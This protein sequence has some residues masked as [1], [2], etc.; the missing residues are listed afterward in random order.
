[1]IT[2]TLLA[3]T[4]TLLGLGA[5][6]AFALRRARASL[7]Y[8][9]H[10]NGTRGKSSVTRLIAAGLRAGG[11]RTCAKITGT[12][13]RMI[14]PDGNEF[15]VY[16][17]A[18]PNV[19]E[20]VRMIRIAAAER[21]EALVL[22]CMALQ[23]HLQAL[24][25]LDMLQATH[26]VITNARPDH[27]DVMGPDAQ[28]VARALAG[29]T[30]RGARLYT[31]EAQH[32]EALAEAARDRGSELIALDAEQSAEVSAEDLA[33]FSYAEHPANVALALRVC[34]D[35]GVERATALAAMHETE[36]DEGASRHFL[37]DYFGR[38]LTFVNG[39]AANDPEST[40]ELWRDACRRYSDAERR[41][42]VVNCRL[43]RADRSRQLGQA[44]VDWP[45]A[46]DLI[47]IGS[48]TYLFARE[49][50]RAGFDPA[51]L[52]LAEGLAAG[53]V[54]ELILERAGRGALV[55]G[56][57]NVAGP[58]LPLVRL[59]RNRARL[60]ETR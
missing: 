34:A 8:R 39:F 1:M 21:A 50:T 36:P 51:R 31:C 16:R 28:A 43:D 41:I 24:T 26:G 4:A 44:C 37:L 45:A 30:P 40:E 18:R 10:V 22:E 42:L 12:N 15:P 19:I 46:D 6:E 17:A 58:G 13:A 5:A 7:R 38:S 14:L 33:G 29:T 20:Q 52:V 27:L 60:P 3:G 23:P 9:I 56:A 53:E 54:F 49:A 55:V 11:I 57:G 2:L 59:F 47:V 32:R 48:G 35:L 25:E